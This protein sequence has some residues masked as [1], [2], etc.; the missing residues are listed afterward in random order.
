MS[1]ALCVIAGTLDGMVVYPR[2]AGDPNLVLAYLV[3]VALGV[4]WLLTSNS[5]D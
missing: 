3:V 5:R 2:Y 4:I 1:Y